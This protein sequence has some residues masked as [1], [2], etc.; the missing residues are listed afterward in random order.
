MPTVDLSKLS[1]PMPTFEMTADQYEP[2]QFSVTLEK[3]KK[4][5]ISQKLAVFTTN[6]FL[7]I[8]APQLKTAGE[9]LAKVTKISQDF[10]GKCLNFLAAQDPRIASALMAY[11]KKMHEIG[12]QSMMI[13]M[14]NFLFSENLI[15]DMH[16]PPGKNGYIINLV[17]LEKVQVAKI[18]APK[19][20]QSI[21]VPVFFLKNPLLPQAD[22]PNSLRKTSAH[23]VPELDGIFWNSED[24]KELIKRN[25]S[26]S[27]VRQVVPNFPAL[28]HLGLEAY[29]LKHETEHKHLLM[30]Y[31]EDMKRGNVEARD[32]VA[33]QVKFPDGHLWKI[34]GDYHPYSFHEFAATGAGYALATKDPQTLRLFLLEP[35]SKNTP[36][37]YK[38]SASFIQEAFANQGDTPYKV[39][40]RSSP[41][42]LQEVAEQMYAL[43][44]Y[45]LEHRQKIQ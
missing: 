24:M 6:Y 18:T 11:D 40:L 31:P 7:Q 12:A 8:T 28:Q 29:V 45:L 34:E 3:E 43:G 32:H 4:A 16:T 33:V 5:E 44:I 20:Q 21:Q 26:V 39:G 30:K 14:N 37:N 2:T 35:D 15:V 9:D 23:Y 27:K 38:L 1:A 25:D 13:F 10:I 22:L 17:P 19:Y 42:K 41:Q 36:P